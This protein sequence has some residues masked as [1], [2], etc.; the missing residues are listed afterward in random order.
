[1]AALVVL[2]EDEGRIQEVAA[3][4]EGALGSAV[5]VGASAASALTAAVRHLDA[6][7]A[8]APEEDAEGFFLL[9]SSF[10]KDVPA[11]ALQAAISA[12][13]SAMAGNTEQR[14]LL[15]LKM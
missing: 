10:F 15:R 3:F 4:L 13:V 12:V 8:K 5:D 14:A 9:V 7:V 6:V 11:D 2:S 1:M